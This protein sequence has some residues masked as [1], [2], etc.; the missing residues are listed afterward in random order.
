MNRFYLF[1]EHAIIWCIFAHQGLQKLCSN[2][3]SVKAGSK[4]QKRLE[5]YDPI[6]GSPCAVIRESSDVAPAHATEVKSPAFFCDV[7][8]PVQAVRNV[9]FEQCQ[10]ANPEPGTKASIF[11]L[12]F[13][14]K[15]SLLKWS[16]YLI[17]FYWPKEDLGMSFKLVSLKT[18]PKTICDWRTWMTYVDPKRG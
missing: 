7:F 5:F 1:L 12:E 14:L 11:K 18:P 4:S 9:G 16:Y 13:Q 2:S 15:C 10:N 17:V 6:S 3:G 8:W